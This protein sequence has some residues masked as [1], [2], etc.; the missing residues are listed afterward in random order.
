MSEQELQEYLKAIRHA[1]EEVK[2]REDALK[3]LVEEGFLTADGRLSPNYQ[4]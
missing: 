4:E 2:S 3:K 1:S